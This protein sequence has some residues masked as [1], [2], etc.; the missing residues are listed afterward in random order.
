M[1]F[2]TELDPYE[3]EQLYY[4]RIDTPNLA[5]PPIAVTDLTGQGDI[6][7]STINLT[8]SA[9]DVYG[10]I[11]GY[12]INFTTP[13]GDPTVI[14]TNDT[15]TTDTTA[16]ATGLI[17][18]DIYSFRVSPWTLY[19]TNSSGNIWNGTVSTNY[20]IGNFSSIDIDNPNDFS[21]FFER[22]DINSTSLFLNVTY[23]NTYDLS[24]NFSYKLARVNNTYSN[25]TSTAV[26]P[27][28]LESSFLFVNATGD[29]IQARCYDEITGDTAKYVITIT[30][31]PLL[32]QI[33]NLRN[34]TYGTFFQI[35]AIDGIT[36][37][38]IFLGMIG[39][40]RTNPMVGIL[41]I[42]IV[43][44]GLAFFDIITYP[45]IMYPALALMGIWAFMSTRKDD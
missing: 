33:D 31:F 10:T 40:N 11:L 20:V 8:W 36:L 7:F 14:Y 21:I 13:E 5:I 17:I 39:F 28:D 32:Q 19:G 12:M 26:P 34:G 9:P 16:Q 25:L 37:V 45:V 30:D 38:V 22:D 44:M 6:D 2:T 1:I 27:D 18:G 41:F 23:P 3:V 29:V 35:G 24:C 42:I 43:T 15:G 4:E